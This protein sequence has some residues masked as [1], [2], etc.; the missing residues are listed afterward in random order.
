[1]KARLGDRG[2]NGQFPA[3]EVYAELDRLPERFRAPIVL[4]HLEGLT[5]EQA[6]VQLGLPV[7]T[8]QRRLEQGRERLRARL[9]RHGI[10]PASGLFGA[11]FATGP[12]SDAWLEAT[13]RAAAGLAAGQQTAAVASATV[14]ALTQ[15]GLTMM[16]IGRL[17][18]AAAAVMAAGVVAVALAGT[19]AAIATRRQAEP[20]TQKAEAGQARV[21]SG[22]QENRPPNFC[23]DRSL[24][25]GAGRRYVG[26]TGRR[27]PGLVAL[28]G[29]LSDRHKQG[30]RDVRHRDERTSVAQPSVPG[31]GRR[32]R[33]TGD[34]PVRRT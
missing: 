17:K 33:A 4:C 6:A 13:V 24:D 28:G 16:F 31:N 8:V 32:W 14:A 11:G 20:S 19:G 27:C 22:S 25:Q 9:G 2:D 10:E 29:R 34:I 3:P 1:M 5:N 15:G 30:R 7:R 23:R 18:I 26:P 12:A 21:E